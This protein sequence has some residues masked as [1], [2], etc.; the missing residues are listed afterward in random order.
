METEIYLEVKNSKLQK[1]KSQAISRTK[2]LSRNPASTAAVAELPPVPT[3]LLP[4]RDAYNGV[5]R[6]KLWSSLR[7][8]HK[9]KIHSVGELAGRMAFTR[10]S[11]NAVPMV[12]LLRTYNALL[13]R[14][15]GTRNELT[16]IQ[17][18][19]RSFSAYKGTGLALT[20]PNALLSVRTQINRSGLLND[21]D[22]T[23][24]L[25]LWSRSSSK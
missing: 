24:T 25:T 23:T 5:R 17:T 14:S 15:V 3:D 10:S 7:S 19:W 2:T 12:K 21:H 8:R 22:F 4:S 9:L 18:W 20:C 1:F 11:R 13:L 16:A 6:H